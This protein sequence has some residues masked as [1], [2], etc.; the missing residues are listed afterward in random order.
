MRMVDEIRRDVVPSEAVARAKNRIA[1]KAY[2]LI[3]EQAGRHPEVTGIEFGGSFA[4]GTWLP[5]GADVDIFVRFREATSNRR[6]E[7]ISKSIGFDALGGYGPY[8]RYSEHPYVEARMDGTMVNVVPVYDVRMGQW[9][10]SADRSPHHT[11]HMR[12]A[13][14]PRM[15]DEVRVLKTFLKAGRIYGAEIATGGFSGYVSEVLVLNLGSFENVLRTFARIRENQ[16]IGETDET[17][18]TAITIVD[19]IDRKRNLAAAITH[20][21]VGRLVLESRAFLK[22]PARKFFR[23]QARRITRRHWENVV[24]VRFEFANRSPDIIWGQ[25]KRATSSLATQL[26]LG[27]FN[28]IRS[29]AFADQKN[30]AYMFF[31]LESVVIP[32]LHV[33]D[34]PEYFREEGTERFVRKNRRSTELMWIGRD[35]R[36]LSLEKRRH[37]GPAGLLTEI[38]TRNLRT[39]VPKGLQG[40]I[41]RGFRVSVGARGIGKSIKEA[42][43]EM[44][45][46]DGAILHLD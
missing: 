7:R 9:K 43:N 42:A 25:V 39:G 36:V 10:S 40:D 20:E 41:R 38:L 13:L 24:T 8:V 3:E 15:R 33:K 26:R 14:T 37:T 4:K 32:R 23:A 17:F 6:F 45:L 27:G 30:N 22:K 12:D 16:V 21:N 2:G 11:R 19:P 44:I 29:R 34:G 18:D 31:L 5:R 35:G 28:V 1:Q 46:T